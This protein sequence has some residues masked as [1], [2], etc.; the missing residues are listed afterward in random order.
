MTNRCEKEEEIEE[1]LK[2]YLLLF[3]QSKTI[4]SEWNGLYVDYHTLLKK[5]KLCD[6]AYTLEDSKKINEV[7]EQLRYL[8]DRRTETDKELMELKQEIIKYITILNGGKLIAFLE[9][10]PAEGL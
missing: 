10:P 2:T 7:N 9:F 6:D 5:Y 4:I 3:H 1:L 8:Q